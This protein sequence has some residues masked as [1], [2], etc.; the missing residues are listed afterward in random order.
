[1]Q[2]Y[3]LKLSFGLRVVREFDIQAPDMSAAVR[4]CRNRHLAVWPENVDRAHL[5]T[6]DE[7]RLVRE[8]RQPNA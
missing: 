8:F 6:G 4:E 5:W 1:M 7:K 3:K 2:A